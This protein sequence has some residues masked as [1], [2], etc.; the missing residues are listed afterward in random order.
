MR[1]K[2]VTIY[3]EMT[4]PDDLRPARTGLEL[5][6]RRVQL[7]CPEFN[8]FFYAAVG[9]DW[10]WID[11]LRWTYDRWL[12]YLDRPEL[13]TWAAYHAGTPAGYFELEQQGPAGVEL[14]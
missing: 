2:V 9:G 7:P 10:Y 12:S 1:F 8:R 5:D 14:A 11:R 3:L 4:S 13:E 6:V